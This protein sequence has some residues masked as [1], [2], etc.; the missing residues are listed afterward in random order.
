[1]SDAVIIARTGTPAVALVTDRFVEQGRLIAAAQ[2]MPDLPQVRLPYPVAGT[3]RG[4]IARIARES[5]GTI[6]EV[7]GVDGAG[8][9]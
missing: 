5:A 8:P 9:P 7:L 3:G 4:S 2:G 6:L 1:M